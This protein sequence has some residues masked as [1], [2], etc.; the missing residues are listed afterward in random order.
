MVSAWAGGG[1]GGERWVNYNH[2]PS[3]S[4]CQSVTYWCGAASVWYPRFGDSYFRQGLDRVGNDRCTE[5]VATTPAVVGHRGI[6]SNR[7]QNSVKGR[8]DNNGG[9][10]ASETNSVYVCTMIIAATTTR[11]SG[12]ETKGKEKSV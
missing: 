10:R 12:R 6:F 1:G 8:H 4:T 2:V 7:Q 3:K 11:S 5:H 9:H